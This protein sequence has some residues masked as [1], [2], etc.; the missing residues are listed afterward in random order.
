MVPNVLVVQADA[1]M[2]SRTVPELIA[3]AKRAP[4]KFTFGSN[5][6][7]TGQHLIG[8]QFESMAGVQLLHVPYKGSGPMT[9][10]LAGRADQPCPSTPSRPCCPRIKGGQAASPGGDHGQ[11]LCRAA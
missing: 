7:G 2:P 4:G 6:N 10:R 1:A 5:G 9:D 8:A 3:Q 11:A